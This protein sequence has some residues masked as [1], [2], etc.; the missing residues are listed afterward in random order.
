MSTNYREFIDVDPVEKTPYG[1]APLPGYSNSRQESPARSDDPNT[2]PTYWPEKPLEWAGEWNG[3]F[4]RGIRNADVETYF[5]CDDSPDEEW[6]YA[7]DAQGHG[8]FYPDY[9]DS[10]RGGLGMEVRARGF[11]WSHVLAQDVI[12]WLY[13][14]TNE[15]TTDYDSV[16]FSQYIDWGIGGT[17]DSG[18]DEGGYNTYLDIAFAWDYNKQGQ[19]GKWG[20]TGTVGYAFLESPGNQ[21]NAMD[22][23]EDGLIDERRDDSDAGMWLDEWPYGVADVDAFREFYSREPH[24]HWQGDEDQDWM[25]FDDSN[26]NGAWDP[27][28]PLNDDVGRDGLAPYHP[29]Y[30]GPDEG[31][32]NGQPDQGEPNFGQTDK[33]E[34]DQL[35]LTG[36]KVFP[37]HEYELINDEENW[38]EVFTKLQPPEQTYLEGG[39]NL[40][41]FFSSGPFPMP[42][43]HTERFSMAL[44]FAKQDFPDAPSDF[45]LRNSSLARKKETVQQIYNADYRFAQPPL[46]PNLS[47]IPN[48]QQVILSWDTRAESSF[49]PFLREFDFEGYKVYRS[50]E[51]FFNENRTVTNA[52]GEET[53]RKEL[54][55]Y[56]FS[57]EYFGLHPVS[58]DG[59]MFN[60][61]NNTGL[62]H[63]Y[64]DQ[65]VINGQTY[66]YALVSYDRGRVARDADDNIQLDEFG[67]T[68]GISPSECTATIKVDISGNTQTD[69]NT[70]VATPR[71]PAAGF[72][73]GELSDS[74]E[75]TWNGLAGP[76]TGSLELAVI[77]LDSL[78]DNHEYELRFIEST[79]YHDETTPEFILQDLT[80][81]I[82]K[83]DTTQ[84]VLAGQEI[85]IVDGFSLSIYN[86]SSVSII[87][88]SSGWQ[89]GHQSNYDLTIRELVLGDNLWAEFGYRKQ[90]YPADYLIMF[91]DTLVD[92]SFQIGWPFGPY[93]RGSIPVPFRIWNVTEQKWAPFGIVERLPTDSL[94]YNQRWEPT[95][96]IIIITGDSAGVDPVYPDFGV[97]WAIRLFTPEEEGISIIPPTAGDLIRIKTSKPFRNNEY[98]RFTSRSSQLDEDRAKDEMDKVYVVPNPYVATSIFEPANVYKSGRG[99]R[100]I[101]F[102]NLPSEC[103]ISIYTKRG[104]LVDF[105][106]HVG[107]GADGQEAWDLVS[108]DGMNIAYGIYFYVVEAY[109]K[110]SVGKFAVI[111]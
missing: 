35:G 57:N 24:P 99:E 67:H 40:G 45:E 9:R 64:V 81:G 73:P 83:V 59:V 82:T 69:I 91:E 90:P 106:K 98:Y 38:N 30:P 52:Y 105:I 53:F 6:L 101:Y 19:P 33:D 54:V 65:D 86:D 7:H 34:S 41:M 10:T 4:G 107:T 72:M 97:A 80:E 32:G 49:D 13:E 8:V 26:G 42:A 48:D 50:T 25:S 111:K 77:H 68:R 36:F 88:D 20:P 23:D 21:F 58:V 44:I 31:E 78:L 18:D 95:E 43:G 12:F 93:A 102:M 103:T 84:L 108:Q 63:Y 76:A 70:A 79:K 74:T 16:Y 100:R 27:T 96:P 89:P 66:Y 22:D 1:W 104:Y 55:Q 62:R 39:Y 17:A 37:V 85:P 15:S 5:V 28:E 2:W 47:V 51:P 110:T 29:N 61:G 14:I 3:F 87:G 109:D 56:D 92:S 60:L 46:K 75:H 71:T 94:S 11:Q